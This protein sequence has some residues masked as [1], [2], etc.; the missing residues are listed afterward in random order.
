MTTRATNTSRSTP[1]R[2]AAKPKEGRSASAAQPTCQPIPA[3]EVRLRAYLRWEAAGKPP[4]DGAQF[5]LEAEQELLQ[6]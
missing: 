1:A 2:K 5:W 3:E 6:K 4:G